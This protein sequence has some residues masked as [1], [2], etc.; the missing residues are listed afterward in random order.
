MYSTFVYN[1]NNYAFS[2]LSMYNKYLV[3]K[4]QKSPSL[5]AKNPSFHLGGKPSLC[6]LVLEHCSILRKQVKVYLF[7]YRFYPLF[8]VFERF[9]KFISHSKSLARRFETYVE[10]LLLCFAAYCVVADESAGRQIP[11]AFLE[12]VKDDFVSKYGGGKG[13]TAPA[14]SLNKEYGYSMLIMIVNMV[15]KYILFFLC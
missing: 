4:A 11:M 9:L 14:N 3:G 15:A 13:A 1:F 2:L 10:L 6:G 7:N 12:R 8:F 5:S